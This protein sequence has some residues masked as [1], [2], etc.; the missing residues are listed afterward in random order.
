MARPNAKIKFSVFA[1]NVALLFVCSNETVF[2]KKRLPRFKDYSVAKVYKGKPA[3]LKLTREEKRVYGEKL[4][5]T[6]ENYGEVD[7]AGALHRRN[8]ELRNVV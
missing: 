5:Y 6:I 7:F 2:A 3:P 1:L 4:Q 8:L